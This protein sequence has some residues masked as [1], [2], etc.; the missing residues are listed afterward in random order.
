MNEIIDVVIIGAG[1]SGL[2][3]VS[4]LEENITYLLLE[5]NPKI[6]AKIAISGGGK[7][8]ITN[9]SVEAEDYLADRY[10]IDEVLR[11]FDQYT[12]LDW[13]ER[14]SLTPHLR[15]S[16]EYFCQNSSRELINIF[17]RNIDRERIILNRVVEDV[18]KKDD[19]FQIKCSNRKSYRAKSLVIASGGLSFPSIGATDIGFKIASSFGH[20]VKE[21]AP[22]L[23]GLTLQREQFFFKELSGTSTDV[24]VRVGERELKGDILFTHR[25]ISGPV[26]LDT[27]LYWRRGDIEIDFLPNFEIE[28]HHNSKKIISTILPLPKSL[29]KALLKEL[30]IE[31]IQLCRLNKLERDR[32]SSIKSYKFS[33]AGNFGYKKAEVTRGGVSTDEVNSKT[34]MSRVSKNLYFTGEVLDVTGRVGGYNFQWAFS[35]AVVCAKSLNFQNRRP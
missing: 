9:Q 25:G 12:L 4:Q 31:D 2:M 17:M 24:I 5:K 1:A 16:G 18:Y 35:S 15:D 7:C 28:P 22:A 13:L 20:K 8:N 27:S 10:F 32:L 23:V 29:S 33:P 34:M 30:N 6:G 26:I 11:E 21:L 14:N 19:I 3:V